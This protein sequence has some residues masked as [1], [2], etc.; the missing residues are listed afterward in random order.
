VVWGLLLVSAAG[1]GPAAGAWALGLHSFGSLGR[2]FAD[3]LDDAAEAPQGA[4]AS[5]GAR[6]IV[7]AFYAT[8]P[9]SLGP[10]ATH[11]LFRLDWNLRM[12]TV[13]GLIGAGGIGQ[14]LYQAQQLFFYKQVLAYVLVTAV[15]ILS[16]DWLSARLRLRIAGT[17]RAPRRACTVGYE[18]LAT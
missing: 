9:L 8:V 6:R 18:A 12:A 10:M 5:T 13:L 17:S 15:L 7:V 1:V 16:V 4:V 14:A 3:S 11:L 2:L